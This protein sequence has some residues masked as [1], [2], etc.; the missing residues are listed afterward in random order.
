MAPLGL[1][2]PAYLSHN[3]TDGVDG[4]RE[5]TLH[6]PSRTRPVQRGD[7]TAL[8]SQPYHRSDDAMNYDRCDSYGFR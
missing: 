1:L 5:S 8:H 6:T 3:E 2:H 7:R 4:S